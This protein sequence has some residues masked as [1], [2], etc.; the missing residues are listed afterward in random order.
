MKRFKFLLLDANVVIKVFSLG[1]WDALVNQCE[2]HLSEIVVSES[3]Y[4]EDSEGGHHDIKLDPY[5]KDGRIQ[6]FSHSSSDLRNFRSS[7]DSMYLEKLD[8]GETESLIHLLSPDCEE[9]ILCSGDAIVFRV[10]GNL[11]V[12]EK[13]I[14]LEE[15]FD[16][17][18]WRRSLEP[19]FTRK[20]RHQWSRTG[21]GDSLYG[22]GRQQD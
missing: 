10:L 6:V 21:L 11:R 16:R 14:S 8:P 7:F 22:G 18:G 3:N 2:I 5:I 13:G 4:F 1:L 20:W 9:L 19:C 15:I 17:F 12:A